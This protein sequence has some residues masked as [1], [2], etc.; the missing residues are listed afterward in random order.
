MEGGGAGRL[1]FWL[2]LENQGFWKLETTF[3]FLMKTDWKTAV[4]ASC[5]LTSPVDPV[6][7]LPR[8]A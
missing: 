8:L 2:L 7:T 5:F 4:P 3:F 6:L 1:D